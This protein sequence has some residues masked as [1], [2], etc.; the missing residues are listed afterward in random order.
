MKACGKLFGDAVAKIGVD[1]LFFALSMFGLKK[2]SAR[3]TTR[4]VVN[5]GLNSW[6]WQ[7]KIIKERKLRLGN[8]ETTHSMDSSAPSKT[9]HARTTILNKP[10]KVYKTEAQVTEL[11]IGK[12][13]YS[14][15]LY[16]VAHNASQYAKYQQILKAMENANPSVDSLKNKGKLPVNYLTKEKAEVL[17]WKHGKPLNNYAKG[18]QIGGDIFENVPPVLPEK[19]GRIWYEAAIGLDNTVARAKQPGTRLLY[20]NDGL[21]YITIDHYKTVI[22]IGTWK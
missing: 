14:N 18:C 8:R 11:D 9:P 16:Q 6:K 7:G 12:N 22:K 19:S 21:L 10:I 1:G 20:S 3:L 17:G 15:E 13:S 5:N 2:A 4:T